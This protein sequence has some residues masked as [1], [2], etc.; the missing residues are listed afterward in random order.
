MSTTS[1]LVRGRLSLA[2]RLRTLAAGMALCAVFGWIGCA[3]GPPP[4]PTELGW[5]AV[6]A[7]DWVGAR[8]HF[9]AA[10]RENSADG[11]A[12]HG[13]AAAQLGARDPEGALSSLGRLAKVDPERFRGEAAQTHG[14]VLAAA[15]RARLDRDDPAAALQAVRA[16]ARLEPARR[17]LAGLL[18][19]TVVAA[20]D[21]LRM[22]G[23]RDEAL[24]LFEEATR[25][26]PGR[27]D[28]WV[29][30]AEILLEQREGKRAIRL[31]EAA[32]QSHP[33]ARQIRSL[34]LQALRFR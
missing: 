30:A 29:G 26:L 25:V 34:T 5:Q 28:G 19:E 15:T 8:T 27:L 22:D 33:T 18:G 3:S 10:L 20:G 21:R 6:A 24:A 32:R 1:S 17:G 31:L 16:L 12:W 2:S 13:R 7:R 14:D 4:S 11:A 23:R 9:D